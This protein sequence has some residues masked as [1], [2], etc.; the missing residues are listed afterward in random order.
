MLKNFNSR[1]LFVW[2]DQKRA[3]YPSW[4]TW[5]RRRSCLSDS[6]SDHIHGLAIL[7]TNSTQRSKRQFGTF[8]DTQV[9]LF[10]SFSF[11]KNLI[12]NF[13]FLFNFF[14]SC[15]FSG[16]CIPY[17]DYVKINP[18]TQL[19]IDGDCILG[20]TTLLNL[21]YKFNVY[22]AWQLAPKQ[23][24]LPYANSTEIL[25]KQNNLINEI[26]SLIIKFFRAF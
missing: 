20:C 10:F 22:Q 4:R 17:K 18:S 13:V 3:H 26:N 25:G 7:S 9:S 16:L 21:A 23:V 8:F 14:L 11:F 15:K 24:W 6:R 1:W 5:L 19:L 12:I 2:C